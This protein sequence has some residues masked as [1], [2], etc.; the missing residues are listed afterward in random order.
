MRIAKEHVGNAFQNS[1]AKVLGY[2]CEVIPK[3]TPRGFPSVH[4]LTWFARQALRKIFH[5]ITLNAGPQL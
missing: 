2:P 5:Q 4:V 3:T 1:R